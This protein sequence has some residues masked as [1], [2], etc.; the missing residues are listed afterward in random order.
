M[1]EV[2]TRPQENKVKE[3]PK[4]MISGDLIVLF[5]EPEK[6]VVLKCGNIYSYTEGR[7]YVEWNMDK[8]TDYNEPITLQNA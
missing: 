3:F 4:I 6:G 5:S 1:I 8:F 7:Y 2:T